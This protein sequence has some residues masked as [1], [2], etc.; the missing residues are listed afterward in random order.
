[1]T[2]VFREGLGE[3]D[4]IIQVHQTSFLLLSRQLDINLPLGRGW[5]LAQP[6]TNSAESLAALKIEKF[7]LL[8]IR[9]S[10][11]YFSAPKD[12]IEADGYRHLIQVISAFILTGQRIAVLELYGV[13]LA[14]FNTEP[15][16]P[17]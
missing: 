2:E 17:I 5:C 11:R 8:P 14:V 12:I 16:A 15:L 7:C 13:E 9:H 6:K 1:M 10:N 3:E 4:D